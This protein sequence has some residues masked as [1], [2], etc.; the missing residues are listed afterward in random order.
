M[1]S[2]WSHLSYELILCTQITRGRVDSLRR[3]HGEKSLLASSF[4]PVKFR[5]NFPRAWNCF[6]FCYWL[7]IDASPPPRPSG[8]WERKYH[9][10]S[11]YPSIL[12]LF[13]PLWIRFPVLW[14]DILFSRYYI[15]NVM[16]SDQLIPEDSIS[17]LV[18]ESQV[19][20]LQLHAME[21]AT[22]LMV[23]DFT[24]FRQIGK[25]DF[26]AVFCLRMADAR[27]G[28]ILVVRGL[29]LEIFIHRKSFSG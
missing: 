5:P 12:S 19:H 4:E 14:P 25:S 7:S 9:N 13:W 28:P 26:Q 10:L 11:C 18:K 29:F 3:F 20:L 8:T 16:S 2:H 23:E 15:K 1:Y 17:E 21:T 6:P 24:I 22:Q 27:Y